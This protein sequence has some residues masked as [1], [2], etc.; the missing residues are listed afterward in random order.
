MRLCC[1]R[2]AQCSTDDAT[3]KPFADGNAFLD[4]CTIAQV[5]SSLTFKVAGV[6]KNVATM[7]IGVSMG[8]R[9]T[10]MQ[11]AGYAVASGATVMYSTLR[12]PV[13]PPPSKHE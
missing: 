12:R 13:K 3:A 8:E 5:T 7:A 4:M 1:L 10:A 6:A 11:V 2:A 9:L